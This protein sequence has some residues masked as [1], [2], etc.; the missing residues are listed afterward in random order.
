MIGIYLQNNPYENEI[1]A[2]VMAFFPGQEIKVLEKDLKEDY[3]GKFY[4]KKQENL[5]QVIWKDEEQA[6]CG[7]IEA[8]SE[9]KSKEDKSRLKA[10]IYQI[11]S[12]ATKK[13]LPWGTLTGIRPTKIV[14]ELLNKGMSDTEI[15]EHLKTTY[16]VSE[17]K[18]LLCLNTA[19]KEKEL[20]GQIHMEEGYSLYIGIPFCPTTCAYCSFTSYPLSRWKEWIPEYLQALFRELEYIA[21]KMQ[22]RVLNAIYIGGGTPTTLEPEEMEQLLAKIDELFSRENLIEYTVEAGRPDSI[23]KEKL[24]VLKKHHI[25]RISINP[26]TMKEETLRTIGRRHT[27]DQIKEAFSLAR[28]LGFTNINMDFI[29]GLPG[30]TIE[31]VANTMAEVKK[32]DP[33]S[34]TIHSLAI[35]RAAR[36]RT[37]QEEYVGMESVNTWETIALTAECAKEMGMEPY[38]LYRQKNMAGNFEN[39]GYAKPKKEGIYNIL[40]MEELQTIVA[41]GAGATTKIVFPEENRIE[42]VENVKDVVNYINRIDEMIER[43]EQTKWH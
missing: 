6:L 4:V 2:L 9:E 7:E 22:G 34:I 35:K 29:V 18:A 10:L 11:L 30:E 17:E 13:E 33:D 32:L 14:M 39:V 8:I 1:R 41:A 38:Y 26:Q 40:I 19:K 27:A 5:W 43:K 25:T 15:L 20:I 12:K 3:P 24:Q 21:Q 23:T 28:E 16:L 36:L 31:D 37:R 42:R